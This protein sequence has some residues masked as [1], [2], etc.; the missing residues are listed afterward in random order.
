MKPAKEPEAPEA[1]NEKSELLKC[2]FELQLESQQTIWLDTVGQS[3]LTLFWRGDKARIQTKINKFQIGQVVIF[4]RDDK[5]FAHRIVDF[6]PE[7]DRWITKGDTQ[8]YFDTPVR[9][10]EFIGVI[11][12]IKKG[13]RQFPV[14]TDIEMANLSAAIGHKLD[15]QFS[16]LPNWLQYLC[17]FIYFIPSYY[18]L[19]QKRKKDQS[20]AYQNH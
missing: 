2:Y 13:K 3:M 5:M 12:C 11:D 4:Y 6:L 7:S 17:Y 16:W 1:N 9:E 14:A 10:S 20:N 18:R 19:K 8:Y 15:Q